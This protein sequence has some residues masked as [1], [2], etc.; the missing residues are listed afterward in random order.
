[1]F[2]LLGICDW[3]LLLVFIDYVWLVCVELW[4][5]GDEICFDN[6][7]VGSLNCWDII[8]W[9]IFYWWLRRKCDCCKWSWI[10]CGDFWDCVLIGLWYV[11]LWYLDLEFRVWMFMLIMWFLIDGF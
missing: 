4:D 3:W 5:L 11:E 2:C 8:E 1:M 10:W 6:L 9:D 7:W